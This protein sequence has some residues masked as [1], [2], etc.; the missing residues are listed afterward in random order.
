MVEMLKRRRQ[1]KRL[2]GTWM[3]NDGLFQ[4]MTAQRRRAIVWAFLK[5]AKALPRHRSALKPS[6]I[7][8]RYRNLFEVLYRTVPRSWMSA[9]S[10]LLWCVYPNDFVIYDAFVHRTL[11]VLQCLKGSLGSFPRIGTAPQLRSASDIDDAVAFY[12]N[13]QAMVKH[14]QAKHQVALNGL[15][16]KHQETYPYDVRIIDK[17]PCD[18][19]KPKQGIL[20]GLSHA[21][22][23]ALELSVLIQV[24][25]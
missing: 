18:D 8:V 5:H 3:R 23:V 24:F 10:K 12:S 15:R 2:V 11:V 21:G 20:A 6:L 7:E 1:D 19:R 16:K 22:L 9:T 25:P 4:G 14:L 13:Y 17:L